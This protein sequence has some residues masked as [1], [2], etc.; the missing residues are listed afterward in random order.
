MIFFDAP[1]DEVSSQLK[2]NFYEAKMIV[3][4]IQYL[5]LIRL[6]NGTQLNPS[7]V[8][9]ITPY[10]AQIAMIKQQFEKGDSFSEKITV[11]TVERYQGGAKNI[12]ILSLCTNQLDQ[13]ALLT[14]YS[15]DGVDRKLNVALTRARQQIIIIGNATILTQMPLY[16]TL[17][18]NACFIPEGAWNEASI[19]K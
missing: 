12:I 6:Q 5:Q 4:I 3:Q 16:K 9:V 8:G 17:I 7:D 13:V 1:V 10:R 14:S 15:D 2:T 19:F 18:E 11:D